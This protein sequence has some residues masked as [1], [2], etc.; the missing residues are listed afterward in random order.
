MAA[1]VGAGRPGS[2]GR[3]AVVPG[4]GPRGGAKNRQSG[5]RQSGPETGPGAPLGHQHNL[6]IAD[7]GVGR[8]GLE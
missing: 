4:N 6:Q 2:V 1:G 3:L 7:V 5:D 8:P